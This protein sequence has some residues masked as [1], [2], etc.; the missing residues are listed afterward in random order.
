MAASAA[1]TQFVMDLAEDRLRATFHPAG[2][3]I[4]G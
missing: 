2:G 3:S 1:I 4:S